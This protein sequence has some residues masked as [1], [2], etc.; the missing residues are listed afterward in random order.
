MKMVAIITGVNRGLGKALAD[1]MLQAGDTIVI[2][3]S[4]S[5]HSDHEGLSTDKF[6]FIK[7]DLSASFNGE[8][9]TQIGNIINKQPVW[10]FNNAGNIQPLNKVGA[11]TAGSIADSVAINITY[12]VSLI[13]YIISNYSHNQI[14]FVNITSGAGSRPI[15][16]WATYCSSKAYMLMFF[17]TLEQ[18]YKE[19]ENYKFYSIDPGTM[20]TGMQ[21]Q[22]RDSSFPAKDY[23]TTLKDNNQLVAPQAAA[24]NIL[25][26]INYPL[27]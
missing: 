23:F 8:A 16:N 4:R 6:L 11:F 3:L 10:L 1:I 27:V 21:Q 2:S 20:D 18:E 19:N 25:T 14:T 22:I 13:N 17:K 12:P 9:L 7:T 15:E 24:Q 5:V 26:E